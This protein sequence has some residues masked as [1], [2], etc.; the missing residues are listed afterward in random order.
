[1][2]GHLFSKTSN[3][4]PTSFKC[5]CH[6]G[7]TAGNI[8]MMGLGTSSYTS[9]N[10]LCFPLL[11]SKQFGS[12]KELLLQRTWLLLLLDPAMKSS[13]SCVYNATVCYRENDCSV[14]NSAFQ[15]FSRIKEE[16]MMRLFERNGTSASGN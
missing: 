11:S 3:I 10:N 5:P 1:M 16:K 14:I 9:N 15:L 13:H 8:C 7:R 2:A 12:E 4:Q 6:L